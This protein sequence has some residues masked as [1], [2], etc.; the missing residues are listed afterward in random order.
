LP[1]FEKGGITETPHF[2]AAE[3]NKPELIIAPSGDVSL[4]SKEGI[5]TAPVGSTVKNASDTEK[6]LKYAINGIGINGMS[7]G[8]LMEQR[9]KQMTDKK[10]VEKLDE[11]SE[12]IIRSAYIGRVIK[13]EVVIKE[14]YLQKPTRK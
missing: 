7:M 8:M 12:N 3:G 2:I 9:T 5:Y 1:Q 4:A 6:L 13:N 10:I 14:N 11:V